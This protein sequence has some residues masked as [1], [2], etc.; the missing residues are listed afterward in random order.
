[1]VEV[2]DPDLTTRELNA[3]LSDGLSLPMALGH[4]LG[5]MNENAYV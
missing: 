4:L 2:P 5:V 1:M 3:L